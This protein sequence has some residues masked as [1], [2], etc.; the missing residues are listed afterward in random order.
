MK[1][2]QDTPGL[3]VQL[4][5][6]VESRAKAL[7]LLVPTEVCILPRYFFSATDVSGM[8]YEATSQDVKILLRQEGIRLSKIEPD[9]VTIPFQAEHD[10]TWI[11]PVLFFGVAFWSQNPALVSVALGVIANHV[12][13]FFRGKL[14][15]PQMRL[16]I[17]IEQTDKKKIV[18][19][20]YEG[21]VEGLKACEKPIKDAM[22]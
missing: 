16:G 10:A 4:V 17:A 13:D 12:T 9:G 15:R 11:G 6:S 3:T 20:N 18:Q 22:K 7:G 14:G 21:P 8:V 19:I 1:S 5:D 2:D